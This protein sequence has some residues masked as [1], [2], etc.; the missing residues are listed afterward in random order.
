MQQTTIILLLK[1]GWQDYY[2]KINSYKYK[3]IIFI[4]IMNNQ[5]LRLLSKK[6]I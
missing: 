5:K 3:I 2:L 6:M 1:E 4:N